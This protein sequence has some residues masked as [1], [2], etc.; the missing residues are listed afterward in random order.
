MVPS[1]AVRGFDTGVS[2]GLVA[3]GAVR[4]GETAAACC[5]NVF[6]AAAARF[7]AGGATV[8]EVM[9]PGLS[10]VVPSSLVE[11]ATVQSNHPNYD[12]VPG[13]CNLL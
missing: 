3:G 5:V 1:A 7:S 10:D 6:S 9:N 13:A 8:Y 12:L 11:S 4:V 2:G